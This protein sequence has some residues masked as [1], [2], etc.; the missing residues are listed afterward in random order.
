MTDE[1]E[2]PT[3]PEAAPPPEADKPTA[4]DRLAKLRPW[5]ALSP[6]KPWVNYRHGTIPVAVRRPGGD[7][8]EVRGAVIGGG[9]GQPVFTL[10]ENCRPPGLTKRPIAVALNPD[11]RTLGIATATITADGLVVIETDSWQTARF[12]DLGAISFS[13]D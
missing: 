7:H 5:V 9:R 13:V 3:A 11:V 2:A 1:P 12:F 8:V 4:L 6:L 10:P